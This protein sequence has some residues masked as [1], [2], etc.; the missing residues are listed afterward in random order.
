MGA[1]AQI[2]N[3]HAAHRLV[4][5]LLPH[6]IRPCTFA[7]AHEAGPYRA[8]V[9]LQ[10]AL[11]EGSGRQAIGIVMPQHPHRRVPAKTIQHPT[12]LPANLRRL[13]F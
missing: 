9:C 8:A 5:Q 2:G 7:A 12:E 10:S 1:Q 6:L 3:D 13:L 11:E 4:R